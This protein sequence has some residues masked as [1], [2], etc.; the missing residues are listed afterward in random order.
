MR[1][2]SL[3]K[4][5]EGNHALIDHVTGVSGAARAFSPTRWSPFVSQRLRQDD[6]LLIG[7]KITLMREH[8]VIQTAGGRTR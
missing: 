8:I 5:I 7:P 1:K 2:E 6:V 3:G 4:V